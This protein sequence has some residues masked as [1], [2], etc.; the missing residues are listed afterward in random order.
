MTAAVTDSTANQNPGNPLLI[1]A[2]REEIASS[3][4]IQ[5][6]RFMELALYHPEH[7]YYVAPARRPG[8]GG[9]F[10]TA[11]EMHPLFG[12]TI[13]R[14]HSCGDGDDPRFCSEACHGSWVDRTRSTVPA[15]L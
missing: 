1:A 5:F 14:Q 12:L 2:I 13:A 11:P 8:R 10:L 6:A 15:G 7:G 4:S 9:E 3:G